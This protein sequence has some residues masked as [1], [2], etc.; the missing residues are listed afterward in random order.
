M[1]GGGGGRGKRRQKSCVD[2]SP[3]ALLFEDTCLC[4]LSGWLHQKTGG[5]GAAVF[6]WMHDVG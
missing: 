3:F 2:S 5:V 4:A 1:G 6:V